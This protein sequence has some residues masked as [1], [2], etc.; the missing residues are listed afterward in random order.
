M[1][2]KDFLVIAKPFK[3][4]MDEYNGHND[5]FIITKLADLMAGEFESAD[6]KFDRQ[7]FLAACGIETKV[8]GLNWADGTSTIHTDKG[9]V[10]V[11]TDQVQQ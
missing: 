5:T 2:K 4:M 11:P 6:Y 8:L 9:I 7:K 3:K 10:T 1:R